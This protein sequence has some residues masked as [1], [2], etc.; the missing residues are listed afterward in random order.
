[1]KTEKLIS[2]FLAVMLIFGCV[3]SVTSF[4]SGD[5][6][7]AE[8][9]NAKNLVS[10]LSIDTKCENPQAVTRAEFVYALMQSIKSSSS[11]LPALPFADVKDDDYFASSLRYAL[12]LKVVSESNAFNP[13]SAITWSQASKM[14]VVA[15]GRNIEAELKGGWP[16]G[17]MQVASSADLN[18]GT[19]LA[20]ADD[21]VT[22]NEFYIVL[23][24]FLTSYMYEIDGVS[25]DSYTYVG[26]RTV[27]EVFYDV[28]LIEGVV[29]SNC[30]TALY[31]FN[32]ATSEGLIE[33]DEISYKYSGTC[34]VGDRVTAYVREKSS[35]T[36]EVVFLDN[37]L[38][39]TLR[40]EADNLIGFDG[41]KIRYYDADGNEKYKSV[42]KYPSVIYNGKAYPG[43]DI[44]SLSGADSWIDVTDNNEDG[45]IDVIRVYEAKVM[46]VDS[47]DAFGKIIVDKNSGVLNLLGDDIF[48]TI[49][50]GSMP[51]DFSAIR[52]SSVITYYE[53]NDKKL[54]DVVTD[55]E[56]VT[57]IL[58]EYNS[59]TGEYTIDGKVYACTDYF[60][61]H[62]APKL[63]LGTKLTV[64][65]SANGAMAAVT[66]EKSSMA[67]YGYLIDLAYSKGLNTSLVAKVLTKDE[68]VKVFEI[69]DK[70]LLDGSRKSNVDEVNSVLKAYINEAQ[71]SL[72]NH[73][74]AAT[75]KYTFVT[76]T[77]MIRYSLDS[78]GKLSMI[79]TAGATGQLK[80]DEDKNDS[81]TRYKYPADIVD[82]SRHVY[83]GIYYLRASKLLHPYFKIDDDA[84]VF[85]IN[86]NEGIDDDKKYTVATGEY[87]TTHTSITT[88][89]FIAYDVDHVG[90]LSAVVIFTGSAGAGSLNDESPAGVVTSVSKA[91]APDDEEGLKITV[92]N[93][94]EYT[95]YYITDQDVLRTM[96]LDT[97][98]SVTTEFLNPDAS[99]DNPGISVGDYIRF[100]CDY[101][102]IITVV[103]KEFDSADYRLLKTFENHGGSEIDYYYGKVYAKNNG[104][105]SMIP[106]ML[107]SHESDRA[108]EERSRYTF[109]ISGLISVYDPETKKVEISTSDEI[110]S[111]IVAGDECHNILIKLDKNSGVADMVIY[112]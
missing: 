3:T 71:Q 21:T 49:T 63:T 33:I 40:I 58:S 101:R 61:K 88:A 102:N 56:T 80:G 97:N 59:N 75:P 27:L 70:V 62:Y 22:E 38:S 46:Y 50:S 24:N 36:N 107:D 19:V 52:P 68:G 45:K 78:D 83:S 18:E 6:D 42:E 41:G 87:F 54:Y 64:A 93:N 23:K 32:A 4:A 110:L 17:Y 109:N 47:A 105:I 92:L 69:S 103:G 26:D 53:S 51:V 13:S 85:I 28:K 30:H 29:T 11:S 91:I 34:M 98:N 82:T 57:G 94:G 1:M 8:A 86:I 95:S 10:A 106:S 20:N 16:Y 84:Q 90:Q 89:R 39:S 108:F 5:V 81:L 44:L 9:Q 104:I 66:E 37:S 65:L 74:N 67:S 14:L 72:Q 25:G 77:S 31:D 43:F 76:A 60:K 15:L 99:F 73:L 48:Y 55:Y 12:A 111:Y 2:L 35:L 96:L 100:E 112:K 79:D 7:H